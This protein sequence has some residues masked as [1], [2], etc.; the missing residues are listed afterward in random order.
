M[1]IGL[2]CFWYGIC[3]DFDGIDGWL[4]LLEWCILYGI[5]IGVYL[6]WFGFVVDWLGNDYLIVVGVFGLV[7]GIVGI[8][9]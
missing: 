6:G 8:G 5:V 9:Y 2:V 1:G 3:D 4:I 7:Y